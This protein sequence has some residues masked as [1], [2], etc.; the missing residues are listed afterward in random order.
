MFMKL[1]KYITTKKSDP[2]RGAYKETACNTIQ[3]FQEVYKK[4]F[5]F[6]LY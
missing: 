4:Y 2:E 5:D 1:G 3:F 6:C